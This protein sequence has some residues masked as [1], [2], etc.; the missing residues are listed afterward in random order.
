MVT[1]KVQFEYFEKIL[2]K[3]LCSSLVT[4]RPNYKEMMLLFTKHPD[5][6]HK[7]RDVVDMNITQNTLNHRAFQFNLI[8]NDGTIEDISYRNCIS[9][10]Q[11]NHKFIGTMRDYIK[12]QI[13]LFETQM[14]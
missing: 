2:N 7:T 9:K 14:R 12:P 13:N 5:Y 10:T 3:G 6:P 1:Q 8:R 4:L 11:E